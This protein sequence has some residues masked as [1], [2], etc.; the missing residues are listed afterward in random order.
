MLN[1]KVLKALNDQINMEISSAYLYLAMAAAFEDQNLSGFAHWMKLQYQ[2]EL[3]HGMRLFNHVAD[4]GGR[5]TLGAIDKPPADFGTPTETFQKVLDHERKVTA[6]IHNLYGIAQE[7]KDYATQSQLHWFID[8]QVEEEKT[9][10]EILGQLKVVGTHPHLV[11]ML[12]RKLA[13]RGAG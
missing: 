11:L 8:E 9:A 3:G 5:V 2:E 7:Q 13:E 6:S 12:D 10:E 4:R 1:E